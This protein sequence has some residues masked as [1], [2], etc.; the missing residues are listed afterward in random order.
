MQNMDRMN[1]VIVKKRL[2]PRLKSLRKIWNMLPR[3][4]LHPTIIKRRRVNLPKMIRKRIKM[5]RWPINSRKLIRRRLHQLLQRKLWKKRKSPKTAYQHQIHKI[6]QE[7]TIKT[8]N[9]KK[10]RSLRR[11]SS[12]RE[13]SETRKVNGRLLMPRETQFLFKNK[14]KLIVMRVREL[15]KAIETSENK[16]MF[17]D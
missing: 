14:C 5:P 4:L 13:P 11:C 7:I 1:M 10:A 8:S 15:V 16:L 2:R 6:C 17:K 3:Q 9:L 12:L